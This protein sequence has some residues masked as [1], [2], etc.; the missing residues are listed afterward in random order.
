MPIFQTNAED[1][2]TAERKETLAQPV[3]RARGKA[4]RFA[5]QR[6]QYTYGPIGEADQRL[7]IL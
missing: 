5:S 1:A 2:E 7:G 3:F 4:S 6:V